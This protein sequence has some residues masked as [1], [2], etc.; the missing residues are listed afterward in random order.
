M[1]EFEPFRY[2]ADLAEPTRVVLKELLQGYLAWAK[3]RYSA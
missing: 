2:R 3:S 1:E